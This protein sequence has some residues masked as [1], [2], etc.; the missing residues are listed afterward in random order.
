MLQ[1]QLTAQEQ[2]V[3]GYILSGLSNKLIASELSISVYTAQDHIK[4]IF[5]KLAISSRN[6]LLPQLFHFIKLSYIS[7]HNNQI[8]LQY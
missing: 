5:N 1:K 4:S 3:V 7:H 2:K 8:S 6:E